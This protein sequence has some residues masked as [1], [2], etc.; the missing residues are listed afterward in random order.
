MRGVFFK[1]G[2]HRGFGFHLGKAG[3]LSLG[4]GRGPRVARVYPAHPL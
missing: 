1:P 3:P 4:G 2:H